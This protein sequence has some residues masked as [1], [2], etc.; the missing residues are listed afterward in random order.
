MVVWTGDSSRDG[1]TRK[2]SGYAWMEVLSGRIGIGN[3]GR[4]KQKMIS[5]FLALAA[6]WSL[7]LFKNMGKIEVGMGMIKE[8]M[9]SVFSFCSNNH[10]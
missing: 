8:S 1:Q 5:G 9:I 3:E 10:K 6:G 2:G 7:V 4:Q